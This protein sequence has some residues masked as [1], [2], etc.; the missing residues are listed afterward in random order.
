M[1][2]VI[3]YSDNAPEVLIDRRHEY[4]FLPEWV[5]VGRL[6]HT[7]AT[8]GYVCCFEEGAMPAD[9][10]PLGTPSRFT[11]VERMSLALACSGLTCVFLVGLST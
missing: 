10:K 5:T 6:L 1:R 2:G 9:C 11:E 7:W 4:R 8:K 3:R